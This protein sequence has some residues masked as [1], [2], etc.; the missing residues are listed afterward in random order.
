MHPHVNV[1]SS[2]DNKT[3]LLKAI[4]MRPIQIPDIT[5]EDPASF[6]RTMDDMIMALL[7]HG[8][9]PKLTDA[10]GQDMLTLY[11][12]RPMASEEVIQ[13]MTALLSA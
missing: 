7:Q 3:P 9:D 5:M 13:A 6:Y 1:V 11:K 10:H 8:A 4:T 12:K 2:W